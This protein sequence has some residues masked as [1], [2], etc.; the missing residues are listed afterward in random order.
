MA[1]EEN[2]EQVEEHMEPIDN[3]AG[4]FRMSQG[5]AQECDEEGEAAGNNHWKLFLQQLEQVWGRRRE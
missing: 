4:D 5:F 3:I 1:A 2:A